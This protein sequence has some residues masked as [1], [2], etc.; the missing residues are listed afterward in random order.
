MSHIT[1]PVVDPFQYLIE[2]HQKVSTLLEEMDSTTEESVETRKDLFSIIDAA[3]TLHAEL[4]EEILY[5]VLENLD[6]THDTTMESYEEHHLVK[7]LL[8]ELQ[9]ADM[10]SEEWTA[11]FTVLKENVEHHVEEEEQILIP[12]AS[13]LLSKK[14]L[15]ELG[16]QIEDWLRKKEL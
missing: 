13:K 14:E 5:P 2:D 9:T 15:E 6:E 12:S 10:Q 16:E 4:E 11:K 1:R 8:E 3:L 7:Q